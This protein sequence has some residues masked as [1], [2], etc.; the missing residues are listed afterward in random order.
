MLSAQ[1]IEAKQ[2]V[3][4]KAAFHKWMDQ[5]MTKALIGLIPAAENS[6][7][8]LLLQAAY[9]AGFGHGAGA[10]AVEFLTVIFDKQD[11][12]R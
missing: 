7:L 10:T 5:P 11:R 3:A 4:R 8:E 1:D 9:D 6:P 12:R 2:A